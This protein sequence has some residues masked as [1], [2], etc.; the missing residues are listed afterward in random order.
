MVPSSV[1]K[2]KRS[3]PKLSVV[4]IEFGLKTI[5]LGADG[6]VASIGGGIVTRGSS[7]RGVPVPS[8]S[9]EKPVPFVLIQKGPPGGCTIP[10]ELTKFL[11]LNVPGTPLSE[12]R[13]VCT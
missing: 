2:I 12:T 4:F 1:S 7:A 6:P 10:Q 8:N 13:L 5:P 3:P 11:S 9:S